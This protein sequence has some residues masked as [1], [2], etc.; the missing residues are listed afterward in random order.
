MS[1]STQ[2]KSQ[3]LY[4]GSQGHRHPLRLS[5]IYCSLIAQFIYPGH[6]ANS[7]PCQAP[8]LAVGTFV[9]S[10]WNALPSNMHVAHSFNSCMSW[11]KGCSLSEAFPD[12]PLK[13]CNIPP[14]PSLLTTFSCFSF[15]HSICTIQYTRCLTY[16]LIVYLPATGHKLHER[17]NFYQFCSLSAFRLYIQIKVKSSI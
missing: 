10:V 3:S 16:L 9:L 6:P 12:N 4:Y 11:L 17:R 1:S 5:L 7:P 13:H 8:S 14:T 15:P 2:S